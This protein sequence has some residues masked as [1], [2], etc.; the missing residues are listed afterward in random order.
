[1]AISRYVFTLAEGVAGMLADNLCG[2]RTDSRRRSGRALNTCVH[3]AFVVVADV[4]HVVVSFE[5]AGQA[6]ETDI[7][8]T[9]VTALSDYTDERFAGF[10]CL[11]A[12]NCGHTGTDS[13]RVAEKRMK[14]GKLPAGFRIR[15]GEYF[16]ATCGVS[17]N[18]AALGRA[19]SSVH[20][21]AGAQGFAAAL[22]G[23]VAGVQGVVSFDVGLSASLIGLQKT[24]A[25]REST[26]L[27]KLN[28]M[29]AH[30]LEISFVKVGQRP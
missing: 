16:Q 11:D 2:S 15:C 4:K 6:S 3:I 26:G 8:R 10:F 22:T 18:Q 17:S 30:G 12:C 20:S 29:F 24:V 21:I 5:H 25:D 9:A 1:M 27:I 7:S 19:H 28:L 23:S 14:P 13:G